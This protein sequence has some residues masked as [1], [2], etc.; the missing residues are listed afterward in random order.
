[1]PKKLGRQLVE[2]MP[3]ATFRRSAEKGMANARANLNY[4]EHTISELDPSPSGL[5]IDKAM[6]ISAGP[7]LHKKDPANQLLAHGFNHPIIA[8]DSSLGY[9]L[10][11][12]LVPGYV[13]VV[14]PDESRVVR[15]FGDHKLEERPEDEYFHRQELD[16]IMHQNS[17]NYNHQIMEL[18]NKHGPQIKA[19]LATSVHPA[20]RDRCLEAGMTVYWWNPMYDDY[21]DEDSLSRR[22]FK[23]NGVPCMV[24]GGNVGT[25]AW[26]FAAAI[27]KAKEVGLIGMDFGYPPDNPLSNTQ[28]Y[29]DL[30]ELFGDRMEEAYLKVYNPYL[31]ETWYADPA[32]YWFRQGFL[33]LAKLA[34]CTTYN[35]TEGGILFGKGVKFVHLEDFLTG[36]LKGRKNPKA[37]TRVKK[38]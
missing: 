28:Y 21:E 37:T 23:L 9:C 11:N 31:K 34:S 20:V 5:T 27:L 29:S 30:L 19:V 8:L 22:V 33:E 36:N 6:V 15:W 10:R 12:G 3:E 4:I 14:D 32:Y 1:M 18:V 35:C 16:P 17:V 24:T 26:V 38:D 7:S 25:S 13:V 2:I